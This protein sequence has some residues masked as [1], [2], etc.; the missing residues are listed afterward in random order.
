MITG[1]PFDGQTRAG[2][3][4]GLALVLWVQVSGADLAKT[5]LLAAVGAAVSFGVSVALK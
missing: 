2:T 1:S 4:G 5:A 3:A